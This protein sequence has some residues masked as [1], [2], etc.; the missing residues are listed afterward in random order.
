[1]IVTIDVHCKRSIY[2]YINISIYQY[3]TL[4]STVVAKKFHLTANVSC[5]TRTKQSNADMACL[6]ILLVQY[7]Q[8]RRVS[9]IVWENGKKTR[10]S[11]SPQSVRVCI[12]T[13]WVS[14]RFGKRF[15][16]IYPH[17]C[18]LVVIATSNGNTPHPWFCLFRLMLM[19][20]ELN[21]PVIQDVE[22]VQ[23][24]GQ[25]RVALM[26]NRPTLSTVVDSYV[27]QSVS[28]ERD[29][30]VVQVMSLSMAHHASVQCWVVD[31]PRE[32]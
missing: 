29:F 3:T 8:R 18:I 19:F 15:P 7:I 32:Q 31:H 20:S 24:S 9:S 10:K 23:H 5:R 1:M 14:Y 16:W 13:G 30:R 12:T 2:Q 22:I 4:A 17:A 21:I 26:H 25:Y 28:S 11:F 27:H 6:L